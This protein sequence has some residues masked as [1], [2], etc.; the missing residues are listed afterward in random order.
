[1]DPSSIISMVLVDVGDEDA[2][3]HPS[4][5]SLPR[6]TRVTLCQLRS[7][8]SSKLRVTMYSMY[9]DSYDPLCPKCQG[10][11]HDTQHLFQCPNDP[12]TLNVTLLWDNPVAAATFLGLPTKEDEEPNGDG[13]QD[14][15][16]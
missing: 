15:P 4:E 3:T 13:R 14:D 12:T 7:G 2:R 6:S 8:Y 11:P 10:S 16:G 5:K 9:P 1:M